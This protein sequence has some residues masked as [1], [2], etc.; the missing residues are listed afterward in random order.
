[1]AE[2]TW[3]SYA[4]A[5]AFRNAQADLLRDE[6]L[7]ERG[8]PAER[9]PASLLL[10]VLYAADYPYEQEHHGWDHPPEVPPDVELIAFVVERLQPP[11]LAATRQARY[12]VDRQQ[13]PLPSRPFANALNTEA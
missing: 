10:K 3:K 5:E 2:R 6:R 9:F 7:A 13:H 4:T 8:W 1:M 11:R 12:V